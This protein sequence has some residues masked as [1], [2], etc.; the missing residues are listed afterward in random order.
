MC[1]ENRSHIPCRRRISQLFALAGHFVHE[2]SP[3]TSAASR[4]DSVAVPLCYDD[5]FG[6]RR[7]RSGAMTFWASLPLLRRL[8]R[9]MLCAV[10]N[11]G[12]HWPR[13]P[14][15][16]LSAAGIGSRKNEGQ[17][18]P[19]RDP[20][21]KKSPKAQLRRVRFSAQTRIRHLYTER[22]AGSRI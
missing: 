18:D 9:P 16:T 12:Q 21:H 8:H 20:P 2:T 7:K 19:P 11:R 10:G 3:E 1:Q 17:P 13:L 22:A 6:Q 4:T 14:T 15:T 5:P